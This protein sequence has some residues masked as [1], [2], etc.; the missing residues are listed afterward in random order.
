VHDLDPAPLQQRLHTAGELVD[1]LVRPGP[2]DGRIHLEIR[3]GEPEQL[4]LPRA[5]GQFDGMDQG[6]RGNAALQQADAA[7]PLALL[8]ENDLLAQVG[9]A[10]RGHIATR[11]GP[12]DGDLGFLSEAS[13]DHDRLPPFPHRVRE[14]LGF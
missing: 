8:D 11:P 13:H 12:D 3:E 5:L 9:G 6:L 10:Q 2:Q 14:S 7:G 4:G 1:N